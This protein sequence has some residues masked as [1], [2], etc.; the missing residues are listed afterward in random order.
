MHELSVK[1]RKDVCALW[2]PATRSLDEEIE[3]STLGGVG[4]KKS[5]ST[6]AESECL[7]KRKTTKT[8][9]KNR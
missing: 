4:G 7:N 6:D 9:M 1:N 2:R 8:R 5:S 3:M